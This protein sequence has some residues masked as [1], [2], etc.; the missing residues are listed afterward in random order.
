MASSTAT[1][2]LET[3]SARSTIV[4]VLAL[5]RACLLRCVLFSCFEKGKK[6][7]CVVF[8]IHFH[9]PVKPQ[10]AAFSYVLELM[11]KSSLTFRFPPCFSPWMA[12][13]TV[14]R[15]SMTARKRI[16]LMLTWSINQA[17]IIT[18]LT[19][20]M[21]GSR[22]TVETHSCSS[23]ATRKLA[24]CCSFIDKLYHLQEQTTLTRTL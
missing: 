4:E 20:I 15:P 16:I 2:T 13:R 17:W 18:T 24:D 6:C 14:A 19:M 12:L 22:S 23:Y 7:L 8:S 3:G 9:A 11:W 21:L 5:A 10:S 1:K